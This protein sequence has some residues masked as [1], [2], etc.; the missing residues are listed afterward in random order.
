MLTLVADLVEG[1]I[2][3]LVH[4]IVIHCYWA[5]GTG[6]LHPVT[7]GDDKGHCSIDLNWPSRP[8]LALF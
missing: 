1:F 7:T 5:L 4:G 6:D 2:Q 3:G 8:R